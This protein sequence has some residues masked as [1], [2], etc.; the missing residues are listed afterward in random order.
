MTEIYATESLKEGPSISIKFK[1]EC[2]GEHGV[3][4]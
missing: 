4:D 2:Q 1:F 3:R